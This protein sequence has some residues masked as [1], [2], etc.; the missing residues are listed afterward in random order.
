MIAELEILGWVVSA[1]KAANITGLNPN[2]GNSRTVA[3]YNE[4]KQNA[5][6]PY[7][8]VS[9][10]DTLNI[11]TEPMDYAF[12]PTAKAINLIVN[13]FSDYSP[14][15]LNIASQIQTVLQHTEVT[16]T[17]Y[18]GNTWFKSCDF[19]DDN[20]NPDR[21]LRCAALRIECRIEPII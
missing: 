7:V 4:V 20:S 6:V 3:V 19:Y 14:E 1:L 11:E 8:R 5:F 2:T 16:T 10:T 12:V 15:A 18:H 13:V 17:N 9:F 21:L